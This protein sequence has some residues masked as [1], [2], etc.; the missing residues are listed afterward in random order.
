VKWLYR[1]AVMDAAITASSNAIGYGT[2][3]LKD[4]SPK[5]KLKFTGKTD[6]NIIIDMGSALGVSAVGL[7]G[8]NFSAAAT[9]T[10]EAN[11]SDA[12]LTPAFTR[13]LTWA[14]FI[15]ET[16][17]LQTYRYWR[18]R[19]QDAT[20]PANLEIGIV[21]LG[22]NIS[23]ASVSPDADIPMES[24]DITN[25]SRSGQVYG[26]NMYQGY[27]PAFNLAHITE[28]QRAELLTVWA[29]QAVSEPFIL[30]VWESSLDV[31]APLYV[32]FTMSSFRFTRL[33]QHGLGY[34]SAFSCREVF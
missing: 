32:V 8:H 12:W 15:A 13:T 21:Y 5:T 4:R 25:V 7:I 14:A 1:N 20:N 33:A 23:V 17:T 29:S 24:Y 6:E 10:L 22:L 2:I 16:F 30:L 31:F 26:Y 27:A 3:M 19:I 9:I 34:S 11:T 18:L 28:A